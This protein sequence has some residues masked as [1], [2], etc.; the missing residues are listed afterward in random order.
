MVVIAKAA[1]PV[2]L[3][4]PA[5]ETQEHLPTLNAKKFCGVISLFVASAFNHK[6]DLRFPQ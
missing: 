2:E 4:L 3:D 1:S 5:S 6:L